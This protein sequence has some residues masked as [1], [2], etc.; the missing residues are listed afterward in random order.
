MGLPIMQ[1]STQTPMPSPVNSAYLQSPAGSLAGSP[2]LPGM[3]RSRSGGMG[4]RS[5]P[6]HLRGSAT[7]LNESDGFIH[8]RMDEQTQET[9][10]LAFQILNQV[11]GVLHRKVGGA[12]SGPLI[13]WR[14]ALWPTVV[15]A[16]CAA[17]R[18]DPAGR[19]RDAV[20]AG[21]GLPIRVAERVVARG[22][23]H[24]GH[25]LRQRDAHAPRRATQL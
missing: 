17:A 16:A 14:G 18:V 10:L 5:T 8:V 22:G 13:E 15:W 23:G 2:A 21:H 3:L 20:A 11:G 6:S 19:L 25:V 1:A 4:P 12:R 9:V 24:S 7:S